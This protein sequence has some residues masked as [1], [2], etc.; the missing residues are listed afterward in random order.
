MLWWQQISIYSVYQH[1]SNMAAPMKKVFKFIDIGA[2]LT[3]PVF[4]GIY[5]GK[6]HHEDDF[7]DMLIR[8]KDV[9]MEKIM[10]TAGCLRDAEEATKLVQEH[11]NLYTTIGCHPT[12]C[13]EFEKSGDPDGYMNKLL[14]IAAQNKDKIV[15]VG[16][17]GL[18]YDRLQ[19]CPKE[20]QLK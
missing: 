2:N 9:G 10:V 16:E 12:R 4:R 5:R 14:D 20:T 15:A 11:E 1:R 7:V 13:G 3:D 8:A 18:D 6:R 19:F 17:F